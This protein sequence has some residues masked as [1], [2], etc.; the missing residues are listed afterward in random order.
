MSASARAATAIGWC[1]RERRKKLGLPE[2]LTEEEK[3]AERAAKEAEA[4]REAAKRLPVKPVTKIA[5]MRDILVNMKKAAAG[6]EVRTAIL[7]A[8]HAQN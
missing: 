2:E 5:K 4:Q 7:R 8:L 1:R 3:E 6:D